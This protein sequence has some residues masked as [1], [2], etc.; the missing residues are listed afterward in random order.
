MEKGE[1]RDQVETSEGRQPHICGRRDLHLNLDV[2]TT[3]F[4]KNVI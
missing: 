4:L 1:A 3:L 2:K